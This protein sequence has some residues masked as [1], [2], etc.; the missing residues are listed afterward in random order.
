MALK[1]WALNSCDLQNISDQGV[2]N[3]WNQ[4]SGTT[5]SYIGTTL[6]VCPLCVYYGDTKLT[7][8]TEI[9]GLSSLNTWHWGTSEERPTGTVYVNVGV[10][11]DLGTS[12]IVQISTMNQVIANSSTKDCIVI[13]ARISNNSDE[14]VTVRTAL[15]DDENTYIGNILPVLTV[16]VGKLIDDNS[17]LAVPIGYKYKLEASSTNVSILV[18]GDE[19]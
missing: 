9:S 10:N 16:P 8:V 17:R 4:Y 6:R 14:I 18:S 2:T 11:I 13:N 5:Y 3:L 7:K 12:E 1:I 15:F 19:Y